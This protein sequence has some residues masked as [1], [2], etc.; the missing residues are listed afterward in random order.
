[1]FSTKKKSPDTHKN[2]HKS[3]KKKIASCSDY[4]KSTVAAFCVIIRAAYII[5]LLFWLVNIKKVFALRSS[6]C[7]H[8][9][10]EKMNKTFIRTDSS[11]IKCN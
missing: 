3:L 4:T 8:F 10:C 7:Y 6:I 1:M 11:Q 2:L 5:K 9:L